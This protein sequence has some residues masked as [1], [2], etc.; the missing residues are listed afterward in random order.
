MTA[1]DTS[2]AENSLK[3]SV[4]AEAKLMANMDG[5]DEKDDVVME[6]KLPEALKALRGR[7]E[8]GKGGSRAFEF[9]GVHLG[10]GVAT[11]KGLDD[12]L[13]PFLYWAQKPEDREAGPCL[14]LC[15][16]FSGAGR[17]RAPSRTSH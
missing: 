14:C 7:V 16:L 2:S 13:T 3:S 9:R 15:F 8:E 17:L 12:L 6:C 11:G 1:E 10:K 5:T 4:T